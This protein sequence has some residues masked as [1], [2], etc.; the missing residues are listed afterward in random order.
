MARA[1]AQRVVALAG[2]GGDA[3]LSWLRREVPGGTLRVVGLE[4]G[5]FASALLEG[6]DLAYVLGEPLHP[7]LPCLAAAGL[8]TRAPWL[9]GAALLPLVETGVVALA[10][11]GAPTLVM[12]GTGAVRMRFPG[13]GR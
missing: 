10:R 4:P 1:L 7:G 13:G 9:D 11:A 3:P 12:D 5:V 2:P 8:R 6:A